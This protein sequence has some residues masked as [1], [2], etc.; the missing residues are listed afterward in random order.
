[1][2]SIGHHFCL[3]NVAPL[4]PI[5]LKIKIKIHKQLSIAVE[6]EKK[7]I[8]EAVCVGFGTNE[9]QPS[10]FVTYPSPKSFVQLKSMI[11][12]LKAFENFFKRPFQFFF[13][14]SSATI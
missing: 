6:R 14:C 8:C 4:Q 7:I 13:E 12:D 11:R 1:M 3:H 5:R 2:R 9:I 10:K